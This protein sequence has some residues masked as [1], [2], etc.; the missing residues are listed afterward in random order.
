MQIF[1]KT[2]QQ[3]TLEGS[4]NLAWGAQPSL[5]LVQGPRYQGSRAGVWWPGAWPFSWVP[6]PARAPGDQATSKRY[7]RTPA[8][9]GAIPRAK[10]KGRPEGRPV[11]YPAV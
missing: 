8:P 9:C 4:L 7:R 10:G 1:R 11:P 6:H 3:L 5:G 2:M